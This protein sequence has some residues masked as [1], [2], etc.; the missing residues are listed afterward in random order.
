MSDTTATDEEML[1]PGFCDRV[2]AKIMALKEIDTRKL[3]QNKLIP[4]EGKPSLG[5]AGQA[6]F[7]MRQL[8]RLGF[9]TI[10]QGRQARSLIFKPNT[11]LTELC[12]LVASAKK[13]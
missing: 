7:V 5:N 2:V 1:T 3:I 6:R 13:R 4:C 10:V 11:K 9:G 8:A 12:Q